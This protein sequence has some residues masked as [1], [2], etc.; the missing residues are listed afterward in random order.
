MQVVCLG[1]HHLL[2][3]TFLWEL[4]LHWRW[5]AEQTPWTQTRGVQLERATKKFHQWCRDHRIEH[6]HG[7]FTIAS[8]SMT[9]MSDRPCLKGKAHN[10]SGV[11]DWLAHVALEYSGQGDEH[12]D[13]RAD[14]LWGVSH[15]L[16]IMKRAPFLFEQQALPWSGKASPGVF[17]VL[18]RPGLCLHTSQHPTLGYKAKVAHVG[19]RHPPCV[20][21]A[22]QTVLCVVF[23]SGMTVFLPPLQ[24]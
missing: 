19:P 22:H 24:K 13:L 20:P 23:V 1:V 5:G 21:R 17:A 2:N 3:G 12:H 7:K 6:S 9:R 14:V 8:M 18:H 4:V 16:Q 11:A 10:M 15:A